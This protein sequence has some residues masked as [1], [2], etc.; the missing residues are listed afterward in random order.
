MAVH[1]RF[2]Q[3]RD[4]FVS[5]VFSF[6]DSN[7]VQLTYEGLRIGPDGDVIA[8]YWPGGWQPNYK[9]FSAPLTDQTYSDIV[10]WQDQCLTQRILIGANN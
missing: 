2:E 8:V 5:E 6:P 4:D 7:Y 10:V 9:M 3:P 1:V